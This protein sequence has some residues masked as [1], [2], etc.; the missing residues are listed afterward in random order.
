MINNECQAR[1][2]NQEL[3][4]INQDQYSSSLSEESFCIKSL[5]MINLKNNCSGCI[6][7]YTIVQAQQG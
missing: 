5:K 3:I 4:M 6:N 2:D 7:L 1:N